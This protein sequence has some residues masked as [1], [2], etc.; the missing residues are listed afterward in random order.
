[1]FKNDRV[2]YKGER[3]MTQTLLSIEIV[4]YTTG[5]LSDIDLKKHANV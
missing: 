3:H 1:M 4:W 2:Y 5:S